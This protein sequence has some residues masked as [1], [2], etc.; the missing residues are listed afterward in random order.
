M[1]CLTRSFN[2]ASEIERSESLHCTRN[3]RET[4]FKFMRMVMLKRAFVPI[5][6]DRNFEVTEGKTKQQ[7]THDAV[8]SV[9]VLL[10]DDLAHLPR[11][12]TAD[13]VADAALVEAVISLND[14]F[15]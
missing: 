4:K 2:K 10:A 8:L 5:N 11:V 12:A 9:A 13:A 7:L 14:F 6:D 15:F 1:H 3:L